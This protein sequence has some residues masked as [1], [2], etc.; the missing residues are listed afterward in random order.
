M[1]GALHHARPQLPLAVVAPGTTCRPLGSAHR[2][3]GTEIEAAAAALTDLGNA[4]LFAARHGHRLRY[5]KERRHW[6]AYRDGRWR[7]DLT[8]EAERAAKETARGRLRAAAEISD[9]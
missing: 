9:C 3:P 8:G 2:N 1:P 6:L 7:T 5:V 4:E